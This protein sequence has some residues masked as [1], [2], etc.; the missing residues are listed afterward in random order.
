MDDLV[1]VHSESAAGAITSSPDGRYTYVA[2]GGTVTLIHH[3]VGATVLQD[4]YESPQWRVQVG[5]L[6]V[7]PVEMA[8]DPD[9]DFSE[10]ISASDP[11]ALLLIAGGRDGLWVMDAS[12]DVGASH[13]AYRVDDSGDSIPATQHSIKWCN[14]VKVVEFANKSYVLALFAA[15][16]RSILRVYNLD[17]VRAVAAQGSETG[18]EL[19]PLYTFKLKSNPNVTASGGNAGA[20]AY[21]FGMAVD[22]VGPSEAYIYIAMGEHGIFRVHM[23]NIG[24]T[25]QPVPTIEHGPWFGDRSPYLPHGDGGGQLPQLYASLRYYLPRNST[26]PSDLVAKFNPYFLDVAVQNEAS[27]DHRLYAAVDHLGWCGFN[28]DAAWGELIYTDFNTT[29]PGFPD[30]IQE[31]TRFQIALQDN[32]EIH[33][34][35]DLENDEA[36]TRFSAARHVEVVRTF[37]V[38]LE[39]EFSTLVVSASFR[40]F[41]TDPGRMNEGRILG[42]QLN[43]GAVPLQ[44]IPTASSGVFDY[45]YA[46]DLRDYID[47][48]GSTAWTYNAQN[49]IG[50]IRG[51]WDLHVPEDQP[52]GKLH[53]IY[54][55]DADADRLD[56]PLVPKTGKNNL[57]RAWF[58]LW[59]TVFTTSAPPGHTGSVVRGR[60][61]R[62]GRETV[63]VG[64]SKLDPRVLVTS[65][66]DAGVIPNGPLL[67]NPANGEISAPFS[68]HGFAYEPATAINA[69]A[70]TTIPA[71][72]NRDL[73]FGV[74][75]D[76]RGGFVGPGT[77]AEHEY[78]MGVRPRDL[79]LAGDPATPD[80]TYFETWRA[81]RFSVTEDPGTQEVNG[82]SV[83]KSLYLIAPPSKFSPDPYSG[84]ALSERQV[85]S[86]RAYYSSMTTFEEYNEY[87]RE[88]LPPVDSKGIMFC[89]L[90]S[91]PQGMWAM[92]LSKLEGALDSA[93]TPSN[94]DLLQ[95]E[96]YRATGLVPDLFLGGLVTHPE[97]W[98]VDDVRMFDHE[99]DA[100]YFLRNVTS[101]TV[102]EVLTWN[103]DL[104]QMR[105]DPEAP[106]T[107]WVMAVPSGYIAFRADD[108]VVLGNSMTGQIPHLDWAP[109]AEFQAGYS[110]MMVRLFDVSDPTKIET[111]HP[112]AAPSENLDSV[113]L[114]AMTIIGP[115][116]KTCTSMVRGVQM[117]D[118]L[119]A[120]RQLLIVGDLVG[121]LFIYDITG[122]LQT[123]ASQNPANGTHYGSFITGQPLLTYAAQRSLSDGAASGVFGLEVCKEEWTVGQTVEQATYVYIG[124]PRVGVE[125]AELRFNTVNDLEL[126][127]I[128]RIQT[129]GN[130]SQLHKQEIEGT[131][132]LFVGDYDAGIRVYKHHPI[133][134]Q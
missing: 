126:D 99:K 44:S 80:S 73:T 52:D 130:G 125:V 123:M 60:H 41:A 92:R 107:G 47:S 91:S 23:Q 33:L 43:L 24:G 100:E 124:L 3:D 66:N 93:A 77:S 102:G 83:D 16:G 42:S 57:I 37:D 90:N 97:Y 6:G 26:D 25:L 79:S 20:E 35:D 85:W 71:G 58:D 64:A 48:M 49:L 108:D 45:V 38:T 82:V 65:G 18:N 17:A 8:L 29:H 72:Q 120:T 89:G 27:G 9:M 111:V 19:A 133:G 105:I 56:E 2:E 15:R 117:V 113:N 21:A 30:F 61:Y 75:M 68:T 88:L 110:R 129:P 13:K 119:G 103:P 12:P 101:H 62:L 114:P 95:P 36:S 128:G 67:F 112:S 122:V 81:T 5:S 132:Y 84:S 70:G 31:G 11:N 115:E 94:D 22:L 59:P 98:N 50:A 32:D 55:A 127:Y 78:R 39:E 116:L 28:L 121:K 7:V 14:D 106:E 54:G 1:A 53:V 76:P 40:R 96:E 4:N 87:V 74:I 63:S 69:P 104:F 51:G 134:G 86:G 109:D 46:Y 34:Y 131:E 118:A 10:P